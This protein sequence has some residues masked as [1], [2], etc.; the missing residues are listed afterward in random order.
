M[1]WWIGF[2]IAVFLVGAAVTIML[3]KQWVEYERLT[4]PLAQIPLAFIDH[5]SAGQALPSIA[6]QRLFWM[7]FSFSGV[8]LFWN[9]AGFFNIDPRLSILELY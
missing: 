4:F 7:G 6:R 1:F 8:V 2:Y 3:R 9:V 5:Q